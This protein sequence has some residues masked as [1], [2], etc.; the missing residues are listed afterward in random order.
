MKFFTKLQ[1]GGGLPDLLQYYKGGGVSR[2]PKFVLRNI[3]T[4]PN[5]EVIFMFYEIKIAHFV[6]KKGGRKKTRPNCLTK[7]H[8]IDPFFYSGV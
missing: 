6:D 1:R 7:V 5:N 8:E 3:W 4:A 2:D